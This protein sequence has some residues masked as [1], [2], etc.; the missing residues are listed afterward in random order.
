MG[1]KSYI[2][3]RAT[4]AVKISRLA[5]KYANSDSDEDPGA[6]GISRRRSPYGGGCDGCRRRG[7]PPQPM[8]I[9]V[10]P[11]AFG[12]QYIGRRRVSAI[13][14]GGRISEFLQARAPAARHS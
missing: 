1:S 8:D 10:D 11:G 3:T 5:A 9:D 6:P 7:L 2:E 13:D 14:M 12:V 4:D